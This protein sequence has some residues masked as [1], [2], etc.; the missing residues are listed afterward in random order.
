MPPTKRETEFR[1]IHG[2]KAQ[3]KKYFHEH[4]GPQIDPG[5][6]NK[7]SRLN[8][9]EILTK[10]HHSNILITANTTYFGYSSSSGPIN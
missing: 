2:V 7:R 8:N 6:V 4:W 5:L 3:K 9:T 1:K 10:V